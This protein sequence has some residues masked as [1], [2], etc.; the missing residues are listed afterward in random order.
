MLTGYSQSSREARAVVECRCLK[1]RPWRSE[2]CLPSCS[3][4]PLIYLIH[5]RP[6][7]P[8]MVLPTVI[9]KMFPTHARRPVRWKQFFTE[10]PS[11]QAYQLMLGVFTGYSCD[12]GFAVN[13]LRLQQ[14]DLCPKYIW[15][16][17][18]C[19]GISPTHPGIAC[20]PSY[21]QNQKS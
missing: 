13:S 20:S 3:P 17:G 6:S 9:K 7:F 21:I 10:H 1:Q 14:S 4:C 5:P 2:Y 8:G 12:L 16:G 19:V 18:F 11:S 15:S